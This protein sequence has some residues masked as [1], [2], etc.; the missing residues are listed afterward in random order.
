MRIL[1][2]HAVVKRH[3]SGRRDLAA[4]PDNRILERRRAGGL[5]DADLRNI[6][7][8]AVNGRKSSARDLNGITD[9]VGGEKAVGHRQRSA[10]EVDAARMAVRALARIENRDAFKHR[11]LIRPLEVHAAAQRLGTDRITAVNRA[12]ADHRVL[13]VLEV[14][15]AAVADGR[16]VDPEEAFA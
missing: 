6:D 4:V 2:R 5:A 7:N 9:A 15:R 14:D 3:R 11:L 10:L 13:D 8:R 1:R 12:V 16:E